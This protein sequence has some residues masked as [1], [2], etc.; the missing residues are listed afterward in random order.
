[1]STLILRVTGTVLA[2]LGLVAVVI[3][4]WFLAALG[5]SGTATFTAEPD[6][7][8]VVLD[9]DVL[10]RVDAP[11]EVTATGGGTVWAGV[12]R[13]SDAEALLGDGARAEATGVDIGDWALT[14]TKVGT[15]EPVDAGSLDIWRAS[16]SDTGTATTTIDQ[17]RA[18]QTL[19]VTAS[20]GERIEQVE[21]VVSDDRWATTAIVLVVGGVLALL[22]GIVLFVR[23]GR[24]RA[25]RRRRSRHTTEE[26]AA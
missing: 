5:T 16:T 14:T 6:Q 8:V 24:R 2:L 17:D 7:R 21:L 4:G 12:A 22:I 23:A 10:N 20:E 3:G 13:P 18:P 15:G 1:M 26:A 19:V 25:G 11:I 9:A